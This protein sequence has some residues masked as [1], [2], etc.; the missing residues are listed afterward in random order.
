MG[1]HSQTPAPK[2]P[3]D[4][5][6]L[7]PGRFLKGGLLKVPTTLT[8]A[9]VSTEILQTAGNKKEEKPTL[10]FMEE[11]KQWIPS[12]TDGLV[13]R[14]IFGRNP[15]EWKGKRVTL[16]FDPSVRFGRERVGGV[17]IMGSP[18]IPESTDI[19]INLP[20]KG[21]IT[22]HLEATGRKQTPPPTKSPPAPVDPKARWLKACAAGPLFLSEDD[23]KAW[24]V[25]ILKCE[26]DAAWNPGQ[27]KTLGDAFDNAVG[28]AK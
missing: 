1:E 12:K 11:P 3:T 15:Q 5:D 14:A 16:H 6:E 27:V 24:A 20:R 25:D 18:D 17:R 21:E 7:Y 10:G 22:V 13:M 19:T 23:A 4:F 8:I 9:S 26:W 2:T 28:K